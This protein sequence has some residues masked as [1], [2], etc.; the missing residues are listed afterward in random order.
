[1]DFSK[2]N[3]KYIRSLQLKKYRDKFNKFV[4]EGDKIC[5]EIL[6]NNTLKLEACF[7]T[8]AW[9]ALHTDLLA[10]LSVKASVVNE[11]QMKQLTSLRTAPE[12]LILAEKP[13]WE[14]DTIP[15]TNRWSLYLDGIQD[16]GNLGTILRIADWFGWAGVF[17]SHDTADLFNPKVIQSTMGAILRV[18]VIKVNLSELIQQQNTQV[19]VYGAA[20]EGENLFQPNNFQPGILVIGN[21]GQGIRPESETQINHWLHIPKG[22]HG[23][24]E[25][26]NAAVACGILC[27]VLSN[28]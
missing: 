11:A 27:A 1:M 26:L 20:M 19:P 22:N 28:Q 21:E 24:A 12:V 4:A 7:V 25:S 16:P 2:N 9:Q 18:P 23:Q 6:T 10:Y 5:K 3:A 13:N 17:C 14:L 15:L 8:A